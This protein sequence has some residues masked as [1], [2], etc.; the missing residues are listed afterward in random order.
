MLSQE[1]AIM[2][3]LIS[4]FAFAV[5]FGANVE[6]FVFARNSVS[7]LTEVEEN[8]LVSAITQLFR[9]LD[10]KY[11]WW[12]YPEVFGQFLGGGFGH[13]RRNCRSQLLRIACSRM[14]HASHAISPH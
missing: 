12:S 6:A 4:C 2:K 5:I 8:W 9:F 3:V 7:F 10:D 11:A 1:I 13:L 14:N